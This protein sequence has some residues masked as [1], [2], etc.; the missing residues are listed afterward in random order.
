MLETDTESGN[1]V[2]TT[3]SS[4]PTEDYVFNDKPD[5]INKKVLCIFW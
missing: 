5:N 4:W 3:S 2:M 1:Y